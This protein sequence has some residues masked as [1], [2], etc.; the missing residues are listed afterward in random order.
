MPSAPVTLGISRPDSAPS[1]APAKRISFSI[2]PLEIEKITVLTLQMQK[3][4][5]GEVRGSVH[6]GWWRGWYGDCLAGF[7]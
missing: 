2:Q 1:R 3:Q 4:R 6:D 5:P 7:S